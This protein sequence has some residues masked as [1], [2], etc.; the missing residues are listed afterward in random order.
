MSEVI[1]RKIF[2]QKNMRKDE[3][4]QKNMRKDE[5]IKTAEEIDAEKGGRRVRKRRFDSRAY[6]NNCILR[7]SKIT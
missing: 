7:D 1:E 6:Q 4:I 5:K 3:K 2:I